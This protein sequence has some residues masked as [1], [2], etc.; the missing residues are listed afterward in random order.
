M[1]IVKVTNRIA[2]VAVFLLIYWVFIFVVNAVFDFRVLKEN[3]TN[4]F[5]LSVLGIFAILLG[6]IILNI[7]YNLT[8][9]AEGRQSTKENRFG[10]LSVVLF[11]ASLVIILFLLFYADLKASQEKEKFLVSSAVKVLCLLYTSD[12]ADE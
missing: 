12:A 8:A 4:A 1:G 11:L 2:L 5:S 3:L 10:K 6:S 9:I 7:M